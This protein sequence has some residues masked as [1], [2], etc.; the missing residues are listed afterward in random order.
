MMQLSPSSLKLYSDCPRRFFFERIVGVKGEPHPSA[1]RGIE[2]HAE[3]EKAGNDNDL[4]N[5]IIAALPDGKRYHELK[6][7][8]GHDLRPTEWE[9]GIL[10]C[11]VDVYIEQPNR[12]VILDFKTGKRRPHDLQLLVNAVA[13]NAHFGERPVTAGFLWLQS[14]ETDFYIWEPDE[15][16]TRFAIIQDTIAAINEAAKCGEEAFPQKPSWLCGYCPATACMYNTN[17]RNR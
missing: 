7:S 13:I 4:T 10:R 2:V 12:H 11:I 15:I 16:S 3:L 6:L 9:N 5:P 1:I 8:L 14:G 17:M